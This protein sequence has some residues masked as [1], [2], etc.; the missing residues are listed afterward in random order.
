MNFL[1]RFNSGVDRGEENFHIGNRVSCGNPGCAPRMAEAADVR[2]A[3]LF[4][5]GRMTRSMLRRREHG[6]RV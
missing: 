6:V 2:H 3:P 1:F 4:S 5:I